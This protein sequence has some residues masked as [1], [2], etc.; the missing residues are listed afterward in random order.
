LVSQD[1][2]LQFKRSDT[3]Y[4]ESSDPIL[5]SGE[6]GYDTDKKSF[7]IGD[8]E[9]T[10]SNLAYQQES[11][12]NYILNGSFDIWQRGT[13]FA[14]SGY[15]A[16]RWYV[17]S[18]I[19]ATTV[20][21][22]NRDA[23]AYGTYVLKLAATAT[24]NSVSIFQPL[25]SIDVKAI[26][27]KTVTFS[28]YA[29]SSNGSELLTYSIRKNAT[30][31]VASTGTWTDIVEETTAIS[32][33]DANDL[34]RYSITADIPFDGTAEGLAVRFATS[35][36]TNGSSINIFD[37]QLEESP[38]PTKFRRRN[39][40]I[41]TELLHCQRYYQV[42]D[43]IFGVSDSVWKFAT[44]PLGSI[45][46][47]SPTSIIANAVTTPASGGTLGTNVSMTISAKTGFYS[48]V[49]SAGAST[50]ISFETVKVIAE[51]L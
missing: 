1:T 10:W 9:S 16:D 31:N 25:E 21:R 27:G 12:Q 4:W 34:K 8:G 19:T 23:G 37:V 20:S 5:E 13:S 46:R 42:H 11:S 47:T 15:T 30:A 29:Y 17:S 43:Y 41:A 22:Q 39:N 32:S 6:P 26:A 38:A 40:S 44:N 2:R 45:L 18:S 3:A 24:T 36:I 48:S 33:S 50:W 14:A 49:G 7:K 35:D 28:F 51:L